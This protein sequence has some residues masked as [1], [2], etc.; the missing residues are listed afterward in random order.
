MRGDS[1]RSRLAKLV[2]H[3][4]ESL[5]QIGL[6]ASGGLFPVQ[7][8][9]PIPGVD[10]E[11]LYRCLLSLGVRAVLRSARHP[12][13]VALSFLVTLLHTRS[14]ISRCIGALERSC[15]FVRREQGRSDYALGTVGSRALDLSTNASAAGGWR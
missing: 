13:G 2:R 15:A 11:P 10:A 6:W 4:R 1:L 14:D 7:T 12:P 8:L 9:K 3:F 5:I